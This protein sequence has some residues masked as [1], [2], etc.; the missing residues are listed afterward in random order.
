MAS[1]SLSSARLTSSRQWGHRGQSS[2]PAFC[3]T[4]S[5]GKIRDFT[6]QTFGHWSPFGFRETSVQRWM[7]VLA[8]AHRPTGFAIDK[9]P[10]TDAGLLHRVGVHD[11]F[12]SGPFPARQSEPNAIR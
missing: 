6:S 12:P 7:D 8:V 11:A 1:V 2:L 3:C 9:N 5:L 4:A 10:L